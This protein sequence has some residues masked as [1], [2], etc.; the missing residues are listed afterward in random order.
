MRTFLLSLAALLAYMNQGAAFAQRP[1]VR[2]EN[3]QAEYRSLAEVN[4]ILVNAEDKPIYLLP[5][6]CGEAK[7]WFLVN[8]YWW[9]SDQKD[10]PEVA[11]PIEIKSGEVYHIPSLVVR[12]D[13]NDGTFAED[14]KGSP[15]RYRITIS[16][17]YNPTYRN[18]SPELKLSV[19]KEF[20][21]IK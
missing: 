19:E 11:Q 17:S 12:V 15:R 10:C 3:V 2:F 4:P 1:S 8:D 7:V 18:G 9:D 6:E 5:K 16:F 13:N 20:R 21:I 14:K